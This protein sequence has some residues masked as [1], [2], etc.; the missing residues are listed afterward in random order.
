MNKPDIAMAMLSLIIPLLHMVKSGAEFFTARKIEEFY[1]LSTPA[2]RCNRP[3][4]RPNLIAMYEPPP[5]P[6]PPKPK[7]IKKDDDDDE[8]EEE[9]EFNILDFSR[10]RR[11]EP[12]V[13]TSKMFRVMANTIIDVLRESDIKR[14]LAI[15]AREHSLQQI[16]REK[17]QEGKFFVMDRMGK[18][19]AVL[20][21]C[22]FCHYINAQTASSLAMT[23]TFAKIGDETILRCRMCMEELT[24]GV[25]PIEFE[26]Y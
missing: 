8:E 21:K 7:K 23:R 24:K 16:H 15:D 5:P 3:P 6:P 2:L 18:R 1:R 26:Q 10:N 13:D 17:D 12:K 9:E 4:P 22:R 25:D 19:D 14:L 20:Y 11:P